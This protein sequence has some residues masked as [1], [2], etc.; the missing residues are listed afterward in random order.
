MDGFYWLIPGVIAGSRRPGGRSGS[1]RLDDEL[2]WLRSQGI[3]AIVTLTE[4]S[5]DPVV[6]AGH[7][8][9]TLHLPV[10]DLTP[11]TP[12]QL[13][14]ALAFIDRQRALDRP[15]LV[16]CLAGQGRTGTVLAA[17]LIRAGSP[18]NRAIAQLREVCPLAVEND[19]QLAALDAFAAERSWLA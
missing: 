1:D 18:P 7:P 16:H 15:V 5:L 4:T 10:I 9:E 14:E 19:L 12:A 11:P 3:G 8:F 17:Y 13:T 2:S 6:L